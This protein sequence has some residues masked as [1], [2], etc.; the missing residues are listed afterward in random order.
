MKVRNKAPKL[1]NG[2]IWVTKNA[3]GSSLKMDP[4]RT[5]TLRRSF[6]T[7]LRKQFAL[8]KGKV[9]KLILEEN[10]FGLTTNARTLF[11]FQEI[12]ELDLEVWNNFDLKWTK[13]V[14]YI[15]SP[16]PDSN[17]TW[18]SNPNHDEKGRFS[19]GESVTHKGDS[20]WKVV[21]VSKNGEKVALMKDGRLSQ[22]VH[23]SKLSRDIIDTSGKPPES[24]KTY[25][26]PSK[27]NGEK[28][29]EVPIS[30]LSLAE[31]IFR[32]DLPK[33]SPDRLENEQRAEGIVKKYMEKMKS[34]ETINPVTAY[35][36]ELGKLE[37]IDGH[38]RYEA[39]KRLGYKK[40]P[41]FIDP[42]LVDNYF[43]NN[44]LAVNCQP[45]QIRDEKGRCGP[46]IGIDIPREKMP[47]IPS[48]KVQDFIT[49][50]NAH[51]TY[52]VKESR[53]AEDLSPTQSRFRQE[54]VD[55]IPHEK[56][57]SEPI[58][59]SQD[60]YILDGTH[61]W[62][63]A[64]QC[65]PKHSVLTLRVD[66]PLQEALALMRSFPGSNYVANADKSVN[67]RCNYPGMRLRNDSGHGH[68]PE[69]DLCPV[70]V[71]YL[72]AKGHQAVGYDLNGKKQ[73]TNANPN[74]DELGRFA[75]SDSSD[76]SRVIS[77]LK[78]AGAAVGHLEHLAKTYV[79]DKIDSAVS[80]LPTSMQTGVHSS[81]A[82]A[83]VGTAVAFASW[84]TGQSLAERVAKERGATDEEARRL[85]GVLS[86]LDMA[87]FKPITFA[88]HATGL[89]AATLGAL[90]MI[91]PASVGY[92][93][94]S[95]ARNPLAT[96]RA[97][98]GIVKETAQSLHKKL[99]V[100]LNSPDQ[101]AYLIDQT[102]REHSYDDWYIA[103]L[104]TA[105]DGT[106]N[107]YD[108]IQV[109]NEAYKILSSHNITEN[110]WIVPVD[111]SGCTWI[112]ISG[113]HVL[114]RGGEIVGGPHELVGTKVGDKSEKATS[115]K[116]KEKPIKKE[117]VKKEST[118]TPSN[119]SGI[120]FIKGLSE[121]SRKF[122]EDDRQE[123]G[124]GRQVKNPIKQCSV[125][126][127]NE[128]S[129]KDAIKG[130]IAKQETLSTKDLK[131]LYSAQKSISQDH[132]ISKIGKQP[133][134]KPV[135]LDDGKRRYVQDGNHTIAARI[136]SGEPC[137]VEIRY[138]KSKFTRN[139][140][141]TSNA[142]RFSFDSSADQLDKFQKWLQEQFDATL[143]G[144]TQEQLWT[145]YIQ[146]GFK[147]GAGRAFEDTKPSSKLPLT[148]PE[149]VSD[150]DS[151]PSFYAGTKD[152]F[153]KSAF[154]RPE[155]VEKV[156]LLAGRTFDDLDGCTANM[157]TKMGRAL[158]DGLIE[159]KNPRE[160]ADDLVEQIDI[161][162]RR[163]EL[164]ARTEMIR[165][166][167]EGQLDAFERLGVE[168]VGVSVEWSTA[169]DLR[170]CP[171]CDAMEDTRYTITDAH[172]LIPLH[173]DCR[174]AFLPTTEDD[175]KE[176]KEDIQRRK[177]EVNEMLGV[178][179]ENA[180]NAQ[181]K[182][183]RWVDTI[184]KARL[185]VLNA[186]P[187][188]DE[189][190][191][192][193]SSQGEKLHK[194]FHAAVNNSTLDDTQKKTY[195]EALSSVISKM[196]DGAV[197][198]IGSN[199]KRIEFYPTSNDLTSGLASESQTMKKYQEAGGKALGAYMKSTQKLFLDGD[200]KEASTAELHAHEL[201]HAI[202]GPN[203]IHS[204]SDEWK[205]SFKSE[206]S[207]NQLSVYASSHP[208]EGFAEFGRLLYG[209]NYSDDT[210]KSHFPKSY[211]YFKSKGLI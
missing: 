206:L 27:V 177:D 97:A 73:V 25:S 51:G 163:A 76:S 86:S 63:K 180:H 110:N 165:A 119:T 75:S 185:R 1:A 91:P 64:W 127:Y 58:I 184:D 179:V 202:D 195:S 128:A 169:G 89:H 150:W 115:K 33:N 190:G 34:G 43:P 42:T 207:N 39:A 102:L 209:S 14:K 139:F 146:S 10:A 18:N 26:H 123:V 28:V 85:R 175:D 152:E 7:K 168:E 181:G 174:C 196:P 77:R 98:G 46:G 133:K 118:P 200:H 164:I 74:H 36:N 176:D 183:Q 83:R 199:V 2:N 114:V 109:A 50:A 93:A 137:E 99:Y 194:A 205:H 134:E 15:G 157:K 80:K 193:A 101:F 116:E 59:V 90:S 156:K 203:E 136:A 87:T 120:A 53:I 70:H 210:V 113:T 129:A 22:G 138:I 68:T 66:L 92:L 197:K 45:G 126:E 131:N 48:D 148:L 140:E 71:D 191:R 16:W 8:L 65:N 145:E 117:A 198:A 54:R 130:S 57:E 81:F 182:F 49:F 105:L 187:N 55:S 9:V 44:S 13:H 125:D 112:T 19:V 143:T 38:H 35:K 171:Q 37:V 178:G 23:V 111:Q 29:S 52:C 62:V 132:T 160:V 79:S 32:K 204:N 158:S 6:I 30:K 56:L 142:G 208:A 100:T 41:V 95:T 172:G 103:L 201:T 72:K 40:I 24:N 106:Q 60:S 153:L 144:K 186:N 94:Y 159:G 167:A 96:L 162:Q 88:L 67:C 170:V 3:K 173:P 154:A 12:D 20:G 61:R 47:Q 161:S 69:G 141:Y 189:H 121:V 211:N 149:G 82:V 5:I 122:A 188:H 147:K 192:F 11:A 151:L 21:G 84:K 104:S 107:V 31:D 135:I 78:A 124:S 17:H 108:A 166:H 155:T 4:T